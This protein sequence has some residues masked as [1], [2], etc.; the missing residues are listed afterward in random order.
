MKKHIVAREQKILTQNKTY[1]ILPDL[2][3]A[4]EKS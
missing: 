2:V 3:A 4:A 1:L